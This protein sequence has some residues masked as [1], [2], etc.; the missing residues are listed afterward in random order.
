MTRNELKTAVNDIC[1]ASMLD[2]DTISLVLW[3]L[4]DE[5]EAMAEEDMEGDDE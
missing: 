4:R 2:A 1:L 5:Y 3:D